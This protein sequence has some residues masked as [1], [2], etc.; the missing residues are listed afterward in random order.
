MASGFP[1]A[2]STPF[3]AHIALY[4]LKGF[5]AVRVDAA[6]APRSH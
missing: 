4:P 6:T 2:M 3:V 1:D 5:D